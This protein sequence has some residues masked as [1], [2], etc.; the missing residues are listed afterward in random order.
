MT[1]TAALRILLV[2]DEAII[3]VLLAE[4]LE[5][6]GYEVC[7]IEATE[8]DAVAAALRCRPDLMI[9]DVRLGDGSGVAAVERILRAGPVPHV[10]VSGDPSKVQALRPDAVV[11]QKPFREADLALA[12]QRALGAVA[13]LPQ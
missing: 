4:V 3:A 2:E 13:S 8:E 12:I 7:A 1:Q 5:G 6:M 10:F 11:M 9:V